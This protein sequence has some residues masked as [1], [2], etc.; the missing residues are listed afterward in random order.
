[1]TFDFSDRIKNLTGNAIREIFKLLAQP[2]IISF[3]G[4]LPANEGLPLEKV[5]EISYEVLSSDKA[6]QVLQYGATEG[7]LPF[8]ESGL[9][10]IKRAGIVGQNLDNIVAVSGGQQGIDLMCKAL[11]NKGDCVLVEEPTYLAVLHILKTYEANAV[12]VKSGDDGIDL[13]D[14]EAKII[15]HKPKMLYLVPTFSNPTGKTIDLTKRKAIAKLCKKHKLVLLEDDPY[16]ELRYEGER[17]PSI[18]SFD[19]DEYVVYTVS[20]SK[21][22]SPGLRTALVVGHK[23]IIRKLVLGKQATD[24]HTSALSQAIVDSYLRK[25]LMDPYLKTVIP[26]Y[27]TKKDRMLNKMEEFFPQEITF[28]KPE[29][30]LFIWVTLPE[31]INAKDLFTEAVAQKVAFVC[32]DS[33]YPNGDTTNTFRLNFSNATLEQID[34]G[35]ERLANV[36]KSKIKEQK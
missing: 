36:I 4:G 28:T 25:G 1:M 9:E 27:K 34:C 35:I 12:G 33:F 6:L 20:F 3:A 15:A 31:Y 10:Y 23:D 2:D 32:G 17:V 14:L 29:G 22:I 7:Y 26:L 19:E 30:G 8:L 13:D 18:K 11:L 21:T 24:V 5:K 16:C